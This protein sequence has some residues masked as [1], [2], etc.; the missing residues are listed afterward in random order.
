MTDVARSIFV[1]LTLVPLVLVVAPVTAV[2][3]QIDPAVGTWELN[4][5]KSR[6]SPGPPMK[7]QTI[8]ITP[9]GNRIRV[10]A[11]GVDGTGKATATE[12]TA[13]Y[14]GTDVPVLFNLVYDALSLRR[15]DRNNA[16]VVRKKGG[17]VVQ[18][19]RR[20]VSEDGK[21]MTITT[22]GVD[23]RGRNVQNV[24]VYDRR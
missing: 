9:V 18:T 20:S 5:S 8:T 13:A 4:P 3:A 24:A 12:Y 15:I 10:V 7:S 1:T 6:Y 21:T 19:A 2:L 14:D 17:K 23:D 11:K 22:T 16:E